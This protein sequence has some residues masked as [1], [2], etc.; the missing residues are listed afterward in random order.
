MTKI[1]FYYPQ[2]LFINDNYL[3]FF[4]KNNM[5]INEKLNSIARF[6]I[7]YLILIIFFSKKI[8]LIA[9]PILL[10]LITIFIHYF[11]LNTNFENLSEI[12]NTNINNCRKPTKNN[13]FI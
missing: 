2:I 9:F 4:P 10:L 7:Y 3:S 13:P 12:K 6:S 5:N 1:W 11:G 8:K